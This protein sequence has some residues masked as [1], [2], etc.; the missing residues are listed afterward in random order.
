[1]SYL[2]G[3]AAE[4]EAPFESPSPLC[5]NLQLSGDFCVDPSTQNESWL[6]AGD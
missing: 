3:L 1:M 4:A 6:I 5:V 2:L